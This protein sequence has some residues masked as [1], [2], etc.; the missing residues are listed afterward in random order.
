MSCELTF[1]DPLLTELDQKELTEAIMKAK[2]P[3]DPEAAYCLLGAYWKARA[4]R[5]FQPRK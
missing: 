1:G 2:Y 4:R 5:Y 3:A